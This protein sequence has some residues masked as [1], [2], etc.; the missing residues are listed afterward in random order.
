MWILF[1]LNVPFLRIGGTN[2][3]PSFCSIK[4]RGR[5]SPGAT[6]SSFNGNIIFHYREGVR[7]SAFGAD[8]NEVFKNRRFPLPHPPFVL[9]L[10]LLFLLVFLLVLR[11]IVLKQLKNIIFI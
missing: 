8:E 7:D 1:Y 10:V 2:G 3:S 9:R 4:G 5:E 11:N 6:Y